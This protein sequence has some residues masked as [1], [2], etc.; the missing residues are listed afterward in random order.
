MSDGIV[1]KHRKINNDT[2][3]YRLHN[4]YRE[5]N[6]VNNLL[7]TNYNVDFETQLQDI[8]IS[9]FKTFIERLEKA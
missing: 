3:F 4:D 2:K 1:E 8:S 9:E 6:I 5:C 7:S